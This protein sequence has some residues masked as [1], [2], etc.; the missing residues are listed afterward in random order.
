MKLLVG[1][2]AVVSWIGSSLL[3]DAEIISPPLFILFSALGWFFLVIV[4]GGKKGAAV[5]IGVLIFAVCA[6]GLLVKMPHNFLPYTEIKPE[7]FFSW[8]GVLAAAALTLLIPSIAMVK[9]WKMAGREQ[10]GEK[11]DAEEEKEGK[12]KAEKKVRGRPRF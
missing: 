5:G 9:L 6:V 2:L 4:I 11:K 8:F 7:S 1:L 12:K 3:A 10:G